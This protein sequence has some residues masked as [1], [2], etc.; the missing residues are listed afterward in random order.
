MGSW[1]PMISIERNQFS[2]ILLSW[3]VQECQKQSDM[4]GLTMIWLDR[5]RRSRICQRMSMNWN[6]VLVVR[7]CQIIST[8]Q[9]NLR[10]VIIFVLFLHI[11]RSIKPSRYFCKQLFLDVSNRLKVY[12]IAGNHKH[13]DSKH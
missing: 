4:P 3:Y 9:N 2:I 12:R 8:L 1:F 6:W 5:R 13:Y 11:W 7:T 10:K